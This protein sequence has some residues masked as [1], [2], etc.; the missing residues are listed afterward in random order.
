MPTHQFAIFNIPSYKSETDAGR[1]RERKDTSI[2]SSRYIW[3]NW[4]GKLW[5]TLF[6]STVVVI[7]PLKRRKK[8]RRIDPWKKRG[9]EE[10][11]HSRPSLF[12]LFA[13]WCP[14]WC[15]SIRYTTVP[16]PCFS[17]LF[18]FLF[19]FL[20]TRSGS[21]GGDGGDGDGSNSSRTTFGSFPDQL[22]GAMRKR[23]NKKKKNDKQTSRLD[24]IKLSLNVFDD[25][26]ILYRWRNAQPRSNI[27][28]IHPPIYLVLQYLS[29][30]TPQCPK[31]K[32]N[33]QGGRRQ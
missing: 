32:N 9:R 7:L 20:Y 13:I 16:R 1:G 12:F 17:T 8:W 5:Q 27:G 28:R 23:E 31:T 26:T 3:D 19:D 4:L 14:V 24:S 11:L 29:S 21:S 2:T 10:T 33:L 6:F 25:Y 15:N 18:S 30:F 22:C